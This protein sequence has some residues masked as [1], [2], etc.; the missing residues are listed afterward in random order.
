MTRGNE[1]KTKRKAKTTQDV[2]I[3][4][5][6]SSATQGPTSRILAQKRK[7]KTETKTKNKKAKQRKTKTNEESENKERTKTKK[8]Q[9]K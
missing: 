9:Q 2:V 1:M 4:Q 5:L 7:A 8:E 3:K 6:A